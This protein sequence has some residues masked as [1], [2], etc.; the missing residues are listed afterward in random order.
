MHSRVLAHLVAFEINRRAHLSRNVIIAPRRRQLARLH[1]FIFL[2]KYIYVSVR[3]WIREISA[4]IK[5]WIKIFL[6]LGQNRYI[7][8][9]SLMFNFVEKG[10]SFWKIEDF[11]FSH[12]RL[13]NCSILQNFIEVLDFYDCQHILWNSW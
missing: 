8:E 1:I 6:L 5:C 7:S 9:D 4:W 2:Y 13:K 11:V 3:W 12:F 10:Q